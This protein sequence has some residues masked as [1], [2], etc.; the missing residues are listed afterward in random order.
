MPRR[1]LWT[2]GLLIVICLACSI[3]AHRY[4]RI[5]GFAM[6][7]VNA[8]FL[9][10]IDEEK[11]CEGALEGMM[12]KLDD[13]HSRFI[14]PKELVAFE[15][16]LD[17]RFV[18]V[19]IEITLDPETRQIAVAS[20][21]FDSPAD[22]AGVRPGDRILRIDGKSTQGMSLED[23]SNLIRG[24]PGASV[25]LSVLHQD[26]AKPV[27]LS[28]VRAA[29]QVETVL[30]YRRNA[31]GSW[32]YWIDGRDHIA[33]VRISSFT[34][35]TPA[36]LLRAIRLLL[37]DGMK[38]LALDLRGNPGGYLDAAT[39]ICN[40]LIPAGQVIVSTRRRDAGIHDIHVSDGRDALPE[41]PMAVLINH[42]SASASEIVAACL[43][44][45]GRAVIVGERSYGKGTV[46]E[47]VKLPSL[48]AGP[49]MLKLTT[50]SYWRP[51]EKNINRG[52][53]AE[54]DGEWGVRPDK[55]HDVGLDT[56]ATT[57]LLRWRRYYDVYHGSGKTNTNGAGS[58]PVARRQTD[59]DPQLANAVESLEKEITQRTQGIP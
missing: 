46:Q 53:S 3:R 22:R 5:L 43:Q 26:E 24:V 13:Q 54:D 31:N 11:L 42:Q 38:G 27:D 45:Y 59:V 58:A 35:N 20:P 48:P 50:A 16:E 41:F 14:P 56:E 52:K 6:D 33:Y 39:N 19:G 40:A 47:I 10:E 32:D 18:G 37:A 23:A 8:R 29:V 12:A 9:G 2:L 36:E 57:K 15:Q 21:I 49:S 17:Q 1:N 34:E 4:S 51:S 28:I 55:D 44:D 7:Q 25:V 30:G